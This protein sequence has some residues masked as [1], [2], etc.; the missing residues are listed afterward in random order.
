MSKNTVP[1]SLT[2]GKNLT[3][4]KVTDFH[5]NINDY[6]YYTYIIYIYIYIFFNRL[7]VICSGE[8]SVSPVHKYVIWKLDARCS[9]PY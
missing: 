8:A 9:A 3:N 6:C 5:T 1:K 4:K 2:G 7:S